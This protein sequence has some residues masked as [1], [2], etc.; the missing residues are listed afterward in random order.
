M[1][2]RALSIIS[3]RVVREACIT[4]YERIDNGPFYLVRNL[5]DAHQG[6]LD[7]CQN[8]QQQNNDW[9]VKDEKNLLKD[10]MVN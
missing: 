5:S 1:Y 9:D 8:Q 10:M 2:V 7:I 3:F 6:L 4:V